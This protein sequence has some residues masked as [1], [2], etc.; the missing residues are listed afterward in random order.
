[1]LLDKLNWTINKMMAYLELIEKGKA[2]TANKKL[3]KQI[4]GEDKCDLIK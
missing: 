4:T 1:M 3:I 2:K